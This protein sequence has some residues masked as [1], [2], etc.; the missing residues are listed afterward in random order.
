LLAVLF[1]L[2]VLGSLT[3]SALLHLEIIPAS[4]AVLALVVGAHALFAGIFFRSYA[5]YRSLHRLIHEGHG[6]LF[7]LAMSERVKRTRT[8]G[9]KTHLMLRHVQGLALAGRA[10]QALM[11]AR[12]LLARKDA[13][14][15]ERVAALAAEAEANLQLGALHWASRALTNAEIYL[16]KGRPDREVQA[17]R[18][19]IALL[20]GAPEEAIRLLM[21]LQQVRAFPLTQLIQARN[22]VWLADAYEATGREEEA[23]RVRSQA[24][25]IAPSSFYVRAPT[26]V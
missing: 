25:R 2:I 14:P 7:D 20:Q 22:G 21:P 16:T 23:Q 15:G 26:T 1:T 5:V 24:R 13:R 9:F 12:A 8:T 18:A 3:S 6:E 10:S 4:P 11:A 17:V 19:R